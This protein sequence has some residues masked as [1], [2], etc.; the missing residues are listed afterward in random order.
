MKTHKCQIF[1]KWSPPTTTTTTTNHSRGIAVK[2]LKSENKD[3]K[4][5]TQLITLI[6]YK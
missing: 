2:K 1:F 6:K 5:E 3:S 4:T